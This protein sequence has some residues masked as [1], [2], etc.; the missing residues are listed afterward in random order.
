[1]TY[2]MKYYGDEVLTQ[3]T[4]LFDFSGEGG[5]EERAE[6]VDGMLEVMSKHRGRGIAA[7]QIG[8]SKRVFLMRRDDSEVEAFFNPEIQEAL[9]AQMSLEGCLSIPGARAQ[10]KRPLVLRVSFVDINGEER[11]ETFTGMD[12]AVVHHEIDHLD[13]VLYLD[14]L[15]RFKRSR[16]IQQH[17]KVMKKLMRMMMSSRV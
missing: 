1:M 15:S 16:A 6:L 13:G 8:V 5:A 2:E 10:V 4:E 7:P 17:R 11:E 12:A 14:R 3:H 9:G